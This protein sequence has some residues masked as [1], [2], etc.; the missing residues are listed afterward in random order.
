MLS[1]SGACFSFDRRASSHCWLWP[2][3]SWREKNKYN[4]PGASL[5]CS[6]RLIVAVCNGFVHVFLRRGK[7]NPT[8]QRRGQRVVDC[9]AWRREGMGPASTRRAC[10]GLSV[11]AFRAF[12]PGSSCSWRL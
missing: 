9:V 1:V 8:P 2:K 11:R 3:S 10:V 6:L 5:L 12:F 7:K 4:E